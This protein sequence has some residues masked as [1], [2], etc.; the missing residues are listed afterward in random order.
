MISA[1]RKKAEELDSPGLGYHRE[2]SRQGWSELIVGTERKN[3]LDENMLLLFQDGG[4]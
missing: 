4:I 1:M 2:T 3:A